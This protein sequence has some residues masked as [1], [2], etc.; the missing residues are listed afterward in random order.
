MTDICDYNIDP[1][2]FVATKISENIPKN[3]FPL[4]NSEENWNFQREKSFENSF[5]PEIPRKTPR[6]KMI[7]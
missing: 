3:F 2:C 1:R 4:K 7:F 6:K 5:S